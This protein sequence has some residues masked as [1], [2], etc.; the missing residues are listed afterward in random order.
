[1]RSAL[2]NSGLEGSDGRRAKLN[3]VPI[4][5]T[6]LRFSATV[7]EKLN[8]VRATATLLRF[9]PTPCVERPPERN[10]A[11]SHALR[12]AHAPPLHSDAC[13]GR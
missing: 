12:P 3:N 6:L 8:N 11:A 5:P 1:L 4:I 2:P 9:A 13:A 7:A 10:A